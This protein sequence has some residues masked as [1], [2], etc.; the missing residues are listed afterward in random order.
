MTVNEVM[1]LGKAG[2]CILQFSFIVNV[3]AIETGKGKLGK[4]WKKKI[5]RGG[6]EL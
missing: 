5:P 3:I 2:T 1:D 4:Y 6:T